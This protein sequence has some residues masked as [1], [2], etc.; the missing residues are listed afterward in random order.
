MAKKPAKPVEEAV[1]DVTEVAT[2]TGAL[3]KV[4]AEAGGA[5]KAKFSKALD[6]AREGAVALGK[7][8]QDKAAPYTEKLSSGEL[9]AEAKAL[10]GQAKERGLE[11]ASEGKTKA[12]DALTALGKLVGENAAL[13]DDKLGS[14][15]GDYA[16]TAAR[17][18]QETG[19][20]LDAKDLE[21]L[22]KEATEFVKK[23]PVVAAGA[24][25]AV[26]FALSKLL[27][28]SSSDDNEA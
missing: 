5:V 8:L 27:G 19:A 22:G 23:N 2:E 4:A 20:K 26:G 1:T 16:R 12:S 18:L 25:M 14:K 10:A 3:A 21:E 6:D 15:Y 17:S 7:E 9:V 13:V 11:L 28:G 24:L